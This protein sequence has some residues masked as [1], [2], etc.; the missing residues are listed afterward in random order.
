MQA[1]TTANS[2]LSVMQISW[3]MS[4][5]LEQT[6][7]FSIEDRFLRRK[8]LL[9]VLKSDDL[10]HL[11]EVPKTWQS[12]DSPDGEEHISGRPTFAEPF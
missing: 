6:T 12:V 5:S 10:A 8:H 3:L 2:I 11:E 4:R 1:S 7:F 9:Q